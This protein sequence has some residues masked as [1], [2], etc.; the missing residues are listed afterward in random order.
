MILKYL[1]FHIPKEI[2]NRKD[3]HKILPIS[4]EGP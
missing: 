3:D 2:A 4:L 1:S